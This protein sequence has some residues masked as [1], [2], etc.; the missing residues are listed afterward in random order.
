MMNNNWIGAHTPRIFIIPRIFTVHK[1]D[2]SKSSSPMSSS[3]FEDKKA[4]THLVVAA[5]AQALM[6][7][8]VI[9]SILGYVSHYLEEHFHIFHPDQA[10]VASMGKK[11]SGSVLVAL[12]ALYPLL[13]IIGLVLC[14]PLFVYVGD[15]AAFQSLRPWRPHHYVRLVRHVYAAWIGSGGKLKSKDL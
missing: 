12:I 11:P 2:T 1:S 4:P 8:G 10:A 5:F 15:F 13:T 6:I 9:I 3:M 14:V 7:A